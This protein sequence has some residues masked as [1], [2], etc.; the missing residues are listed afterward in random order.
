L[1][2]VIH[3]WL[4]VVWLDVFLF[5]RVECFIRMN[6]GKGTFFLLFS[7]VLLGGGVAVAASFE[8]R[9]QDIVPPPQGKE[10]SFI[11][12]EKIP[13][14]LEVQGLRYEVEVE[15]G[16]SAYDAMETLQKA[17]DLNFKGKEFPGLGFL[18]EEINGLRQSNGER[19]YW[20]YSINGEKAKIGVSQYIIQP[21]D[22]ITWSYEDEEAY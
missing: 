14:V 2:E 17:S 21:Y 5:P 12:D 16:S 13:F 15:A 7:V 20:I 4:R 8:G 19:K 22:I 11:Q 9:T 3:R 1:P 10:G 18:V 6:K